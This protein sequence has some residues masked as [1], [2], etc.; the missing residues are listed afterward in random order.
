MGGQSF[1]FQE[2]D[3]V[4]LKENHT[5]FLPTGSRGTV[6]CQHKMAPLAYEVKFQ[7]TLGE[8]FGAIL[9]EYE[10]EPARRQESA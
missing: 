5:V 3:S 9:Y 8:T 7:D 6:F 10:I 4:A 2:G 1:K